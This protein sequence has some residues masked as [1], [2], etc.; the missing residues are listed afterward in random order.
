MK[1]LFVLVLCLFIIPSLAFADGPYLVDAAKDAALAYVADACETFFVGT[2]GTYANRLGSVAVT[3]GAGNGDYTIQDGATEGRSLSILTQSI[4]ASGNGTADTWG[5]Y[6]ADT[7]TV[8]AYG[9]L[10][11]GVVMETSAIYEFGALNHAI[12]INDPD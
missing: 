3:V 2:D 7:T 1:K 6:D 8:M 5:L 4:T 11:S 10:T 12:T 9:N